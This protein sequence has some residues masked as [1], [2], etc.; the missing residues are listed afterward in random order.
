MRVLRNLLVVCVWVFLVAPVLVMDVVP[1]DWGIATVRA[2]STDSPGAGLTLKQAVT[3]I[4]ESKNVPSG[5]RVA[6]RADKTSAAPGEPVTFSVDADKDC[7]LTLL[8]LGRQGHVNILWPNRASN[9]NDRVRAGQAVTVPAPGQSIRLEFDGTSPEEI[10]IAV[11]AD[12]PGLVLGNQ[13]LADL[14][15]GELKTLPGDPKA[16]L[17]EIARRLKAL[18]P[19]GR[20]GAAELVLKVGSS[21]APSADQ[22]PEGQVKVT[23]HIYSGRPDPSWILPAEKTAELVERLKRFKSLPGGAPERD[24]PV[25]GYQGFTIEGL[26]TLG[27]GS[28]EFHLMGKSLDSED[29]RFLAVGQDL[30]LEKWVLDTAGNAVPLDSKDFA[31]DLMAKSR[32]PVTEPESEVELLPEERSLPLGPEG[33]ERE[34][35]VLPDLQEGEEMIVPK[36]AGLIEKRPR[37]FLKSPTYEPWKWN[38]SGAIKKNNCYNYSTNKMTYTYAQPGNQCGRMIGRFSCRAVRDAVVCDGLIPVRWSPDAG[39]RTPGAT[40]SPTAQRTDVLYGHLAAVIVSP[41]HDYHWYRLDLTNWW[42]HKCGFSKATDKDNKGRKIRDPKTCS[43]PYR[44]F[45]GYYF[46]PTHVRVKGELKELSQTR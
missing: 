20:W 38:Q 33:V 26:D 21:T 41:N 2:S 14:A 25:L 1:D 39:R 15:G 35:E 19:Q 5:I 24:Y 6:I 18:G 32:E 16:L 10:V 17:T 11:A 23:M 45:C 37:M 44:D 27:L 46:V 43:R 29:G 42:S 12:Q 9:W 8:H 36:E 34:I 40:G 31:L 22:L 3:D 13:D 4:V 7:H 28:R 30:D